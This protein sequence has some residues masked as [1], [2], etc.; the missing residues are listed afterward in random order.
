M[1]NMKRLEEWLSQE[2]IATG[3]R[4]VENV[5]YDSNWRG[6]F[7]VVLIEDIGAGTL[8]F[9]GEGPSRI[10][11]LEIAFADALAKA[12]AAALPPTDG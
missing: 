8:R 1:G 3:A 12:E 9:I 4:Q 7:R 11:G 5:E 6:A 10:G 2:G